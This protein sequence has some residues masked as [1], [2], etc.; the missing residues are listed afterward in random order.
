MLLPML[1][2][3]LEVTD[4]TLS[5]GTSCCPCRGHSCLLGG[6]SLLRSWFRLQSRPRLLGSS[7]SSTSMQSSLSPPAFLEPVYDTSQKTRPTH[8]VLFRLNYLLCL[9]SIPTGAFSHPRSFYLIII[10]LA[11]NQ[12][13][14]IRI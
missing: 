13:R 2:M 5:P 3:P 11:F 4:P 8:C 6:G 12:S 1:L 7:V 14:I 9:K 10:L